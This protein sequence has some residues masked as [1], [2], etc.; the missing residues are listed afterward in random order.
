[1]AEGKEWSRLTVDQTLTGA[2]PVGHPKYRNRQTAAGKRQKRRSEGPGL[3]RKK[4]TRTGL[5]GR[6]RPACLGC[7]NC[8]VQVAGARPAARVG[9]P[10]TASVTSKKQR[11]DSSRGHRADVGQRQSAVLVRLKCGFDSR[12]RLQS[13]HFGRDADKQVAAPGR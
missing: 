7:R 13:I 8:G 9:Q 10:Q 6:Q 4:K 11:C 2:T 3:Q 1:M 12:P 5:K